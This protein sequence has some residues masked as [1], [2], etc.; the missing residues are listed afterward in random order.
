MKADGRD[1]ATSV[2]A[3]VARE[4]G[5]TIPVRVLAICLSCDVGFTMQP[6]CP[7]CG[8]DHWQHVGR[9]FSLNLPPE[10]GRQP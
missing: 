10:R 8:S 7:R 3:M 4:L 2:R 5:F 6:R 9:W 1:A